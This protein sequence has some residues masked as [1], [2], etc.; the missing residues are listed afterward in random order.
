MNTV[1]VVDP[2]VSGCPVASSSDGLLVNT[3]VVVDPIVSGRRL[4]WQLWSRSRHWP[5]GFRGLLVLS[6]WRSREGIQVSFTEV[7][8][9]SLGGNFVY[10]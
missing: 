4:R 1:V 9:G 5:E 8:S 2:I 10:E 6:V 3:V 7:V